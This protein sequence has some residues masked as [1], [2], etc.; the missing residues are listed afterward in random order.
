MPCQSPPSGLNSTPP[1]PAL[2]GSCLASAFR[3]V[4]KK[5]TPL[6]PH[7]PSGAGRGGRGLSLGKGLS[8]PSEGGNLGRFWLIPKAKR[9]QD[10]HSWMKEPH[11]WVGAAGKWAK[12]AGQGHC[13]L[14]SSCCPP[15]P[16]WTFEGKVPWQLLPSGHITRS[17][18]PWCN[19]PLPPLS[20]ETQDLGTSLCTAFVPSLPPLPRSPAQSPRRRRRSPDRPPG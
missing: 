6:V 12:H 5:Q 14:L 11:D 7:L 15:P 19:R 8:I 3:H 16:A 17:H 4:P 13:H 2:S 20:R 9:G 10:L 1:R 18:Q